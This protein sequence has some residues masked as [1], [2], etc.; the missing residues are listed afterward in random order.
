[1]QSCSSLGH[2]QAR[3]DVSIDPVLCRLVFIKKNPDRISCLSRADLVE[4]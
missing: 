4:N 1:M 3:P 2:S